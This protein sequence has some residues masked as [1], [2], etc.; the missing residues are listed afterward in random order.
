M[1]SIYLKTHR[2]AYCWMDEWIN[3]TYEQLKTMD[4]E[5]TEKLE[6]ES[7]KRHFKRRPKL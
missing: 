1:G 4:R 3:L 6:E 5:Y 7:Q 2:Q